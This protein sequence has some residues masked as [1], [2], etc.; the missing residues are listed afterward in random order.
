MSRF[1]YDKSQRDAIAGDKFTQAVL[2]TSGGGADD[3]NPRELCT[4]VVA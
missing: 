1:T 2:N 3:N 4:C